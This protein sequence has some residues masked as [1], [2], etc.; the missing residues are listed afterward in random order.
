[1]SRLRSAADFAREIAELDALIAEHRT[2]SPTSSFSVQLS[3]QSLER[4]RAD[5]VERMQSLGDGRMLGHELDIIFNGPPVRQHR[6]DAEF[7]GELLLKLQHLLQAMVAS[8]D[9]T[10][11]Q[12][13]PFR[14]NVREVSR[15]HFAG[16]FPGSFGMRLEAFQEQPELEGFFALAP[17][18]DALI[19]LLRAGDDP[20]EVLNRLADFGRRT[21]QHYREMVESLTD[22]GADMRVVW[23]TVSGPREASLPL[24]TS[25][26]LLKTLEDVEERTWAHWYDG[27]LDIGNS[28]HGRFGFTTDDGKT[29]DGKVEPQI[30]D[31][32][33]LYFNKHCR[34]WIA[35]RELRHERTGVTRL[36]HR[37]QELKELSEE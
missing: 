27:R 28:R 12:K 15:L 10:T 19:G 31:E 25:T 9:D 36:S 34:A 24:P 26:R 23:P 30:V 3:L 14:T 2:A 32:L 37:L 1:M 8:E 5:L 6:L 16:A 11:G 17:T 21:T 7:M 29:F 18:L 13:G 22:G 33:G 20:T 35:T 4:R